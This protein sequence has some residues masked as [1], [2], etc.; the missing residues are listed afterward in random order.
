MF[1][2]ES[3]FPQMISS[4]KNNCFA[5]NHSYY[6]CIP[7]LCADFLS[8]HSYPLPALRYSPYLSGRMRNELCGR[9]R[10]RKIKNRQ[11]DTL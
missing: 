6:F 1:K 8:F 4:E 2:K 9:E 7:T 10:K 3:T 11:S 5:N